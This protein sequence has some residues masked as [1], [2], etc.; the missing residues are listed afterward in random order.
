MNRSERWNTK[1]E[2]KRRFHDTTDPVQGAGPIVYYENGK[3]YSDDGESHIAVVGRTGKGKS[4]CCSMPFE[5]E[6]LSK[7]ESLIVLD[8]KGEG[9]GQI[10]QPDG[11]AVPAALEKLF[12][13]R[14]HA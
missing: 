4:Q 12:R 13:V 10:P 3:K 8:P 5:R 7:R 2:I 14:V 11:N 1:N 6:C 9:H